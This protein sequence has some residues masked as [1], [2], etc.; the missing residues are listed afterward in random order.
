MVNIENPEH[1]YEDKHFDSATEKSDNNHRNN[2]SSF[3]NCDC[4]VFK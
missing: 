4:I 1:F 2:T 3:Y